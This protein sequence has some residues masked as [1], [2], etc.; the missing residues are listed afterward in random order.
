MSIP[1][2]YYEQLAKD[3]LAQRERPRCQRRTGTPF[4]Y[5]FEAG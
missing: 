5:C 3:L 1:D 4:R 2:S